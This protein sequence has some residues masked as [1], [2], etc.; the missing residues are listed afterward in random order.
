M[1]RRITALCLLTFKEGIRDRAFYGIG[2]F[3]LMIMGASVII[4]SFFFRELDK[5]T[6][7]I[8][9]SAIT[10]AGLLMIFS[11][12]VNLMYKD[13]DKHTIYCVIAK[14]FSRT[15]Y[16]IGKFLGLVLLNLVAL[17]ILTLIS[18]ATIWIIKSQYELYFNNFRWLGFYEAVFAEFLMFIVLNSV[19]VFFSTITSSSFLTLLFT[20]GT[21][22]TGQTIEEVVLF[23]KSQAQQ[24]DLSKGAQ[25][26][27]TVTQYLAPN[28]SAYDLKIKVSH[29][30][31]I[32]P[33]Y[34][35]TI[36]AYSLTYS[37]GLLIL[38]SIIFSRRELN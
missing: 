4:I 19:V 25:F 37:A 6:L 3:S 23:I 26:I 8:N 32:S 12:S 16:L 28:L 34:L 38:S 31:A 24:I 30:L 35:L 1:M 9:L 36:T 29:G 10:F 2:L 18:T 17:C 21:Y 15:Q 20:L 33:C 7:D 27:I 22:I 11:L 13:I 14:P 5:V